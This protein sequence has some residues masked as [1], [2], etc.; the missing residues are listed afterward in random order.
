MASKTDSGRKNPTPGK[1]I[2]RR[3]F[4]HDVSLASLALALP[5]AGLASPGTAATRSPAGGDAYY[6]PTLTGM[7]GTHA[8]AYEVAHQ[9]AREGK[10]FAMG[11]PVDEHYDLVVVGAGISGLAAAYFYRQQHGPESRILLLDNHDDF[12]GHAKRNEFHQAGPMRLSWGGTVN[13]EHWKYSAVGNRL[14]RELGI[15][16]ERLLAD[17]SFDWGSSGTGL[18]TST[19][20]DRDTYGRDVLIRGLS[21][22][23]MDRAALLDVVSDIPI[24]DAGKASLR[25]FLTSTE[26]ALPGYS[27]AQRQAFLHGTRYAD[28][29]REQGGLTP[30]AIQIF[31]ASMPGIWGVRADDLSV[32][33]CLE[34]DLP[35]AHILALPE[36][37]QEQATHAPSAMFPD[38]N[39]SIA[40][41]LVRALIPSAFP[42][43][44]PDSDPFDIV[45]ADLDYG[46]LDTA[47]QPV[48]VRLNSTV[49]HVDNTAAGDAVTL[50]YHED[51]T[52]KTLSGR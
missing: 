32:A 8:G 42:G 6:P 22:Q 21:Y 15:D 4:L 49:L 25:R 45:T 16:I 43:M 24:S 41:L 34:S 38:G 44:R 52:I 11:D 30:D 51:G 1:G 48:R 23:Y 19:W 36:P 27:D 7:R 39:A 2:T 29:L 31:S 40:R 3:D 35:G 5:R 14:L 18:E 9:L 20:F 37:V 28:F 26:D 50:S 33:E 47:D 17:F 12:G 46:E 13:I 10:S